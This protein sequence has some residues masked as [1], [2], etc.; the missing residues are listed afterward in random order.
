MMGAALIACAAVPDITFVVADSGV[1]RDASFDA[2]A[3]ASSSSGDAGD[4]GMM[5]DGGGNNTC[6]VGMPPPGGTC[7][8]TTPCI[9]VCNSS[10]CSKCQIDCNGATP[11]CCAKNGGGVSCTT[12]DGICP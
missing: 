8:G 2:P 6:L 9:G 3:E 10:N 4:S 12:L 11:L 5:Q 7:C 1:P